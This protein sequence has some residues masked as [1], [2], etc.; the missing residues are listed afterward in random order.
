LC[1]LKDSVGFDICVWPRSLGNGGHKPGFQLLEIHWLHLL[2][3]SPS[4]FKAF[5]AP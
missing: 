4:V 1:G 5:I 2:P 3:P